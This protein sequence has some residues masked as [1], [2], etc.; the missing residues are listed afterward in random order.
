[1]PNICIL[2]DSTVQFTH[3]NFPGHELVHIIPIE[4]QPRE[5]AD[6][7]VPPFW[8]NHANRI[9]PPTKQSFC[10]HYER[11]SKQ[12]DIIV[13]LTLSGLL[14]PITSRAVT[15][16]RQFCNHATVEVIDSMTIGLGLG[17][18]VQAAAASASQGAS[19]AEIERQI[20]ATIPRI[21]T[22]F[23]IP[24]LTCLA[25][26]GFMEYSQAM[27]G[28]MMGMLPIF[29]IEEGRLTPMEKVRTQRHLFEAFQEFMSEFET[30]AYIALLRGSNHNSLRSRPVHQFIRETFP[31]TPFSEHT[32]S[33]ILSAMFGT[34]STG[35]VVIDGTEK[36]SG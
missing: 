5:K 28:E 25:N 36:L 8:A 1:M 27:V 24:E 33:P 10:E 13:V 34:Q 2:T 14:S 19:L 12:Y 3:T 16:S 23:C 9:I 30:P 4:L 6:R 29:V 15:A 21:Y 22:L 18:L 20:R 17:F 26:S 32:I 7:V 35:L 11:L 31:G